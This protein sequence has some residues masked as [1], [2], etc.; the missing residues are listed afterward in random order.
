MAESAALLI[1][2]ILPEKAMR[3]LLLSPPFQLRFLVASRPEIMS[4]VPVH[5]LPRHRNASDQENWLHS[6]GREDRRHQLDPAL[7]QCTELQYSL[8]VYG[9]IHKRLRRIKCAGATYVLFFDDI[10]I[11]KIMRY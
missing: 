3:Q 8:D 6:R 7:R 4:R 5:R 1:D 9:R 2:E 11:A 10:Y